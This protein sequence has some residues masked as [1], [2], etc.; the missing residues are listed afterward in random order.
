MPFNARDLCDVISYECV[1]TLCLLTR[2]LKKHTHM[3]PWL[4][5]EFVSLS[6]SNV[7]FVRIKVFTPV[8]EPVKRTRFALNVNRFTINNYSKKDESVKFA[9]QYLSSSNVNTLSTCTRALK[10][11]TRT[12]NYCE[13]R[14]WVPVSNV[15]FVRIKVSQGGWTPVRESR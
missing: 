14:S 3:N 2:A 8:R 5:G 15:A 11:H 13:E 1:C 12:R 6:V 4:W 10:K 9:I 7:A